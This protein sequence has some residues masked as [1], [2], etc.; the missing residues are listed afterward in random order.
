[1]E[2]FLLISKTWIF[3]LVV[4][5]L[6]F[7]PLYPKFPLVNIAGTFVAIRIEDVL[8]TLTALWWL[9]Y[10]FFSGLLRR[11]LEDKL[12]LA[13]LLFFFVTAVSLF[14]GIFL[15]KT[16]TFNLGVMHYLR[17]VEFM[18]LLP[19]AYS[20]ITTKKQITTVLLVVIATV[21]LVD[22]YAI[23][24]KYL[25]WPVVSTGNSEFAKGQILYLTPGAR[26]N[27]TFAG[28]YDLAVYLTMFLTTLAAL[29]FS[30]KSF[31]LK[32]FLLILGGFS[33]LVLIMTAARL[34]FVA[35]IVGIMASLLLVGKKL[36]IFLIVI[37]TAIAIA[38]PSQ[39]RDRFISTININLQ[40]EIEGYTPEDEGKAVRNRLNIPTLPDYVNPPGGWF[41]NDSS[42][43]SGISDDIAPGE[44]INKTDLGVYRSFGIRFDQEWPRAI[45]GFE[46]NPLLGTGYSSLGIATDNDF[47]R[48][49]GEVGILG[50]VAFALIMIEIIKRL[51]FSLQYRD[52]FSRF[53]SAATLSLLLSFLINGL[54]IDVL[55]AS[56]V[57]SLFWLF[58]GFSLA[59][60]K[61]NQT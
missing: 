24:Q 27:S 10:I 20:L 31:F 22:L 55:E 43:S 56:K 5:L 47:L 48:M 21:F 51:W 3:W 11:L 8:I 15:T 12:N 9:S 46:K 29:F 19:I 30:F 6:A 2:K 61:I 17:R 59:V 42:K 44:P 39:L 40:K 57:A 25:S 36:F 1:M 23:G 4:F 50:T 53:V 58:I 37:V 35:T 13:I 26:V 45:R 33:F 7:I 18:L 14:S 60:E 41:M 38:Y 32:V 28:H 49:L 34:S 52:K 54:F 16:V